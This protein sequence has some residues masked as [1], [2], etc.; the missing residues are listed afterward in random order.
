MMRFY[1]I[2]I[3][4]VAAAFPF[5]GKR[6]PEKRFEQLARREARAGAHDSAWIDEEM[7]RLEGEIE[8]K[9]HSSQNSSACTFFGKRSSQERYDQ[10]ARREFA[11][12]H[13]SARD[14]A[15]MRELQ[16]E[17]EKKR[18]VEAARTL[19]AEAVQGNIDQNHEAR[20]RKNQNIL[21]QSIL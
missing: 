16:S 9:K 5:F 10:L 3:S 20:Q 14:D 4:G 17:I 12:G 8:A 15:E 18:G 19:F 7:R 1:M 6:S 2:F 21:I 13:L 11:N